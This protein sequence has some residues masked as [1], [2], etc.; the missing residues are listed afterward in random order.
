MNSPETIDVLNRLYAIHNRSLP[1]YL[2]FAVPFTM[3]KSD[4]ASTA[5]GHVVED[6]KLMV[7]RLGELILD[8][9]GDLQPGEFPMVFTSLH[10][11]GID[12]LIGQVI[13]DLKRDIAIF[14][15]C[16]NQLNLVPMAKALAEEALG[17]AK[18]HLDSLEE[19]VSSKSS[20]H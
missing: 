20:T 10:D 4:K 15:H 17:A 9:G 1:M 18:G 16:A 14:D 12:Y 2:S 11:L 7:D 19:V 8:L 13:L 6:Q 5:L 3:G